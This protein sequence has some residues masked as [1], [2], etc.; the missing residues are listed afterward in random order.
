MFLN[1]S[2]T[3]QIFSAQQI[4]MY[5]ILIIISQ[6]NTLFINDELGI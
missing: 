6:H 2:D 1:I 3:F 4:A 5:F